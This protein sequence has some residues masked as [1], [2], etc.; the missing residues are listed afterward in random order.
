MIHRLT[1]LTFVLS[2]GLV[3]APPEVV[4][5]LKADV[6]GLCG[7]EMKGRGN[8]QEGLDKAAAYAMKA[9]GKMG[10]K[11]QI[12]EVPYFISK[13]ERFQ[14]AFAE[15]GGGRP[16]VAYK[17][18]DLFDGDVTLK[19]KNAPLLY[20]G[21]GLSHA[22]HDDLAEL[23][24][25]GRVVVVDPPRGTGK[26]LAQVPREAQDPRGILKNLTDRGAALVLVSHPM[27]GQGPLGAF[28]FPTAS[29]MGVLYK[30]ALA[31]AA[32]TALTEAR[33]RLAEG[34]VASCELPAK[35]DLDVAQTQVSH[36][37][38][39]VVATVTGSD[40]ILRAEHIV[41]GAHMDHM[42]F[43]TD[44]AGKEIVKPGSDDNASGCA[45]VLEIA[46]QTAAKPPRRSVTFILF[47]GEEAGLL[48]SAHWVKQPT[49]PLAQVKGMVNLDCIGRFEPS[50]A[51]LGLTG[52]GWH[53]D[54]LAQARKQAPG[55]LKVATDRGSTPFAYMSDH[56]S[57]AAA[58]IPAVF[59][60]TGIHT[61]L[62]QPTDTAD[63]LNLEA[64]G[65]IT[66]Y[67]QQLAFQQANAATALTFTPRPT[68]GVRL[69]PDGTPVV[70]SLT[71]GG[72]GDSLKL[73]AGDVLVKVA[74][75][76]IASKADLD[77]V[78]DAH[79]PGA[80]VEL[81]WTREGRTMQGSGMLVEP[82]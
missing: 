62:H 10:L 69:S 32:E 5:R 27:Q 66:L 48:G 36:P 42:G 15:E 1:C 2:A 14:A 23:D 38:P 56:A 41:V 25:K 60:F 12:Q 80:S 43:T 65:D 28:A 4:A 18:I 9:F 61:D 20:V 34:A 49:V 24:L 44:A 30:G 68:L 39:N 46:R 26:A 74:G 37:L 52:L 77:R 81:Q 16:L 31:G 55:S 35:L 21:H 3:A 33:K 6:T 78:L 76:A 51:A 7:P 63:K 29:P 8:G 47:G 58:K 70:K 67:A 40:P 54:A 50:K 71:P 59:F 19:L 73:Q 13:R 17:D 75:Q 11:A 45:G 64:M 82:K 53:P 72:L 57:F 22:S 79:I